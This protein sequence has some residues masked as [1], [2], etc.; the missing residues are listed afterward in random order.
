[1]DAY[2]DFEIQS[3]DEIQFR[4]LDSSHISQLHEHRSEQYTAGIDVGHGDEVF[5]ARSVGERDVNL[6][7]HQC[8]STISL[9]LGFRQQITHNADVVL[10]AGIVVDRDWRVMR[11]LLCDVKGLRAVRKCPL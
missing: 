2:L 5:L 11:D 6:S 9:E 7:L 4:A 10:R 8:R 1:M 3:A